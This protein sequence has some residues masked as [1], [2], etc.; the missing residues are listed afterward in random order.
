MFCKEC[1]EG[2]IWYVDIFMIIMVFFIV[3]FCLMNWLG[4]D[5]LD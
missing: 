2:S 3:K 1:L 4:F 5:K